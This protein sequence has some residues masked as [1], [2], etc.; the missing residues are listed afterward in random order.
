MNCTEK[1]R[2]AWGMPLPQWI[3]LLATACDGRS[4]RKVASDLNV[5]PAIVSL[6]LR[7]RHHAPLDFIRHRVESILGGAI[8]PC[9]VLGPIARAD[10]EAHQKLPYMS[11]N[12]LYVQLFRAYHGECLY[13]H[14]A[15]EDRHDR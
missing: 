7:N 4:L 9:P 5:S 6:A 3:E 11:I 14:I 1:A 12:P 15:K 8:I 13:S 10:C 2:A